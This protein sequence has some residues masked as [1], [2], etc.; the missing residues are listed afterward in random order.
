L[1]PLVIIV[2]LVGGLM[3]A[4]G[5]FTRITALALA[6][7][8]LVAA[9]VFHANFGDQMQMILFMKNLSIAGGFL[10]LAAIGP[11]SLSVDARWTG[12]A[13]SGSGAH[14]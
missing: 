8:T 12:G 1:L 9:G 4:A 3:I 14:A 11:G 5:F 10:L 7:F 2:E 6:G 13:V